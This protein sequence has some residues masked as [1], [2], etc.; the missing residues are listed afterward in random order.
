MALAPAAACAHCG[1][2]APAASGDAPTFCCAGCATVWA[3]LHD[4]GLE[5]YY[6]T[7]EATPDPAAILAADELDAAAL[8]DGA[9]AARYVH[10][11]CVA[12]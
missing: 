11:G 8:D 5:R 10:D 3:A 6:V 9:F 12:L 1:L 4:A 2:P 7:R